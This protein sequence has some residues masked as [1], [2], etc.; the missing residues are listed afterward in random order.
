MN[1]SGGGSDA[2][3]SPVSPAARDASQR[4]S[5][6]DATLWQRLALAQSAPELAEFWL[7]LQCS[8]LDGACR[9]AVYLYDEHHSGLAPAAFWPQRGDGPTSLLQTARRAIEEKKGVVTGHTAAASSLCCTAYPILMDGQARGAVAVEVIDRSEDK[10]RE[11]MRALQWGAGWIELGFLRRIVAGSKQTLS[12]SS[13]ALDLVGLL[14]DEES[15]SSACKALVTELA[16]RLDCQLV[17]LGALEKQQLN[18]VALSHSAEFG[19]QMNLVKSLAAAMQ[20]ATDQEMALLYPPPEGSAYQIAREHGELARLLGDTTILTIPLLVADKPAG[21][22][23]FQRAAGQPFSQENIDLCDAVGALAGPILEQKRRDDRFIGRKVWD[24]VSRQVQRLIGPELLGRKIAFASVALLVGVFSV[25]EGSYRVASPARLEGEV[26]RV[27]VAPF[28]GYIASQ[29]A[30]AGDQVTQGDVL[31]T[32]DDRDLSL[33]HTRWVT[34]RQQRLAEYDQMMAAKDRPGSKIV[35]AQIEQ[36]D[37]HIAL[38][39]EQLKRTQLTAAF[40]GLVVSG[41]LSQSVGAAVGRGEQLFE[42]APLDSYRVILEV[43]ESQVLDIHP[44]QTGQMKAASLLNDT[45]SYT[46]VQVVPITEARDGRNFFRVEA[47][48]TDAH[49]RLR[50]GME[51]VGK[52]EVGERLLVQIWTRDLLNWL[53]LKL[54]AWW[55]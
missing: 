51:G 35:R 43:D 9:A 21:A 55:P 54:W 14:L 5:Y 40:D 18:L 25:L 27:I 39:A 41:D 6:L 15:Y 8:M 47:T 33:E 32:L 46:I 20:E 10:L 30:R 31:A 11:L 17:A 19:R 2:P 45:L 7:E 44:G 12:S 42:L 28:D 48:L 23:L 34:T 1:M 29:S 49:P 26:Q 13:M 53:R 4:V 52:T 16:T 38:L 3:Q 36:A 50:P 22:L 37:A 24:S